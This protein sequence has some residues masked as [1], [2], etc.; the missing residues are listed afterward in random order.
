MSAAAPT[1]EAFFTQR[2]LGQRQASPRT[3]AAYRDALRLLLAF[4]SDRT[5]KSP[6]QLDLSDLDADLISAFLTQLEQQRHNSVRT[7]NA[8]LAAIRSLFRF[9]A[10]RH[11][12][13]AGLI[14]RVL[15]IPPKRFERGIVSFLSPAEV[16]AVINAPDRSR[17]HGK[18]DH[19]LLLLAAQTGLRV[20]ELTGLTHADLHLGTG[21]HV[22]SHGKGRKE[23]VT[24]LT[25]QTVAVLRG[26][27]REQP[28]QP[29]DPLFASRRGHRLSTDA[30]ECLVAKYA[31]TAAQDC[32]SLHSKNV[33][34]HTLRH[35]AAMKLL[36]SG[37]DTSVIALWMG[38]ESPR[39]T[40]HYLHADLELKERALAR[41]IPPNTK[42]GR[43]RPPDAL[44]AFLEAL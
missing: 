15:A 6:V 40:Q 13:H 1:I 32:K 21:A 3:I 31:A 2:L 36:Q 24:P 38:H 14:Q 9:A 10:L 22:R 4:A 7:R 11:P 26:W 18:R 42:P 8:R 30:V 39:S 5:G 37:V 28:G 19:A 33:T 35:S 17:W 23:R 16:D 44:L 41:T 27:L 12:E 43:Y 34:P 20:S 25:P 29:S